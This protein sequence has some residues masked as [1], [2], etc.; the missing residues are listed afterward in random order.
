MNI[1]KPEDC[2]GRGSLHILKNTHDV[3]PNQAVIK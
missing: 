3:H 2:S 1:E